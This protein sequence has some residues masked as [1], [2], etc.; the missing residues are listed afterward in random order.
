MELQEILYC[1]GFGPRRIC[2]GLVQHGL[3]T[4][5]DRPATDPPGIRAGAW[6]SRSAKPWTF[7]KAI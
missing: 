3:V 5:K 6:S 7:P 2:L 1:Q 4:V